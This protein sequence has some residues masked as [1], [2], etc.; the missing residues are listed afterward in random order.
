M[1]SSESKIYV[2]GHQGMVGSAL[3]RQLKNQN[4]ENIITRTRQEL[5]LTNQTDVRN[6]MQIER[7]D[8]VLMAA[9]KV[10]GIHANNV[11]AAEFIYTNLML[12]C[13][14]IHQAFEA[15]VQNIL[16]LGSS[17]IYPKY[18]QQ[19]MAETALLTGILESTNEPY[20]IAK[21]AGIKLCESYNR[22]YGTD[23]RS[24]MPCNLYGPNDNFHLENSHVIPA[25][26]KKVH[27]A[28]M[29]NQPFVDVWGT[30]SALRE[31]LHVDDLAGACLKILKT[32]KSEYDSFVSP[33]C[34]H[35]NV[36]FGEDISISE[37][38]KI[39]CKVLNYSGDI[40]YDTSKPDGSPQKLMDTTLISNMGWKPFYSLEAGIAQTYEWFLAN[41]RTVR[42]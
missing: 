24:A 2:S 9:A 11:Y 27:L 31:F 18:A 8:C 23:Y 17:C 5:D 14:L 6:F 33:M 40:G 34:S 30:G 12:E 37:L 29:T 15:D 4:F 36:G 25:L 26:I 42:S 21:I 1:I 38:T 20:A 19:P 3:I 16:F 10:G 7:P 32:P 13:N 39:I 35:I 22:Q 41:E 28:K